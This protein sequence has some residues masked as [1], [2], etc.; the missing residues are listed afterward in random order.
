MITPDPDPVRAAVHTL[1][2]AISRDQAET[3]RLRA[4]LADL[5]AVA[6]DAIAERDSLR[7]KIEDMEINWQCP[8]N[9]YS[10]GWQ[11][12]PVVPTDAQLWAAAEK[13]VRP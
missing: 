12:R 5:H 4:E 2:G 8:R 6:A 13:G 7:E 3:S 11:N 1:M 9:D 10:P